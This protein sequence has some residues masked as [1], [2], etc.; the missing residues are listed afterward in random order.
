MLRA[1]MNPP[2]QC[3]TNRVKRYNKTSFSWIRTNWRT[4]TAAQTLNEEHDSSGVLIE[5]RNF[6]VF[7]ILLF[8]G[9]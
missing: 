8:P 5:K 4:E 1:Q 7:D 9:V 6:R 3:D 2:L